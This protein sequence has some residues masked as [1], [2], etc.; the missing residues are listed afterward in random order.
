MLEVSPEGAWEH[1][2]DIALITGRCK[3]SLFLSEVDDTFPD[4]VPVRQ[5]VLSLPIQIRYRLA[6]DGKVLSKWLSVF[7]CEPR[8]DVLVEKD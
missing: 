3:V 1:P 2:P 8:E 4:D 6:Y 7:D 5:W